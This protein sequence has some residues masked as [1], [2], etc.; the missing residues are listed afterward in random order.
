MMR[1]TGIAAACAM[2][3]ASTG[4]APAALAQDQPASTDHV[5]F[6]SW[7]FADATPAGSYS[8]TQDSG[9]ALTLARPTMTRTYT[10]PYA[11]NPTPK[12]YD[13]GDWISPTVGT[14]FGLTEL[15]SSWDA[16]TPGGSWIEVSVQGVTAAGITSNWYALGRWADEDIDF[17]STSVTGQGNEL[18]TV[19]TDTLHTLNGHTFTSYRIKVAE[20][21]PAGSHATPSVRMVG[22]MASAVP[23]MSKQPTSATSMTQGKILD[24]PTYSQEI[25]RGEFPEYDNGGEAWCSPTSTSMDV[26]YWGDGPTQDQMAYIFKRYPDVVDPQVD[27]A[28]RHVFDYAYDG[29]GNWPF[30]TAYAATYG[31]DGFVTRL[32]SLREAE[33]F[34]KAGI[35]LVASIAFKSGQ[36]KGAGYKTSGHL[37]VIVGFTKT[38]DVVVNDP[39]SH[40]EPSDAAVRTTY[41]R[42]QFE[43]D[44][45]TA[46]GGTVYVIHPHGVPLPP[47]PAEANW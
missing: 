44:W 35:P 32:R 34:I 27:Y 24:V 26:A 9:P 4:L 13:E 15:V 31:L 33:Q 11:T 37:M 20:M 14:P 30:N 21:R 3:V 39:A 36:L 8:G 22:A 2:L 10:D 12:P 17:H 18:A 29:A 41:D 16:S 46:S 25:H 28:A 19:Y 42:A 6:T 7:N 43:T 1:S 23:G 47:A 38:G 45:L 5:T 40:L